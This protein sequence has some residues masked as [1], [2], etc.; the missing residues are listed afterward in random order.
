MSELT[1]DSLPVFFILGRPRSGTSLLRMLFDAH[2][3]VAI[4]P[5][6]PLI[7]LLANK[8]S[9]ISTWNQEQILSFIESIYEN[10]TFGHRTIQHLRINR[11]ALTNDL[12]KF[13]GNGTLADLFTGLN[14]HSQS[15]F[16]KSDIQFVGDKNPLY[17]IYIRL[18]MKVFPHAKFVCIIR[19]YRDTFTSLTTMKGNPVEAPVLALQI[20]RWRYVV[21]KFLRYNQRFPDR[22]HLV[23]YENLVNH[24]EQELKQINAFL[25]IP[26]DPSVLS[27]HLRQESIIGTYG[28]ETI[29]KFHQ[30]LLNPINKRR[31]G[32]WKTHLTSKQ[33]L[34]ADQ[35]AG[36]YADLFG[37]ERRS[38]RFDVRIYLQ[39]RPMVIY[40]ILLFRLLELSVYLPYSWQRLL[41][42]RL[43]KLVTLYTH[44][45]GNRRRR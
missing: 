12:L 45:P 22:F 27:Y 41:A 13:A 36:R 26:Y 28:Q 35:I 24:P 31:V 20:S 30:S 10:Q 4:P 37:Y 42:G 14:A 40:G 43:R 9:K 8:F 29:H 33:V 21:K 2:P 19:D 18:L 32:L 5:E 44:M 7:P 15:A 16:P 1:D 25:S 39:T 38:K 23:T 6:F 11:E 17:S 34:V 3:Q